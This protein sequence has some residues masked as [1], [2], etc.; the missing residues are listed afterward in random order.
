M[1]FKKIPRQIVCICEN[2]VLSWIQACLRKRMTFFANRFAEIQSL[3]GVQSWK[4]V[5]SGKNPADILPRDCK[6]T[7]LIKLEIWWSGP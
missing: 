2:F 7:N 5:R 4:H 1:C 6:P 3:S